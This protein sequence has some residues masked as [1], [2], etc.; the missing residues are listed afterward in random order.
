M[1]R[2]PNGASLPRNKVKFLAEYRAIFI[3]CFRQYYYNCF[4]EEHIISHD[5]INFI[6]ERQKCKISANYWSVSFLATI[7]TTVFL[8][9]YVQFE[10]KHTVAN[11]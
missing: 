7:D 5:E 2:P 9:G 4:Y 11:A 1:T 3:G 8:P 10:I 6:L